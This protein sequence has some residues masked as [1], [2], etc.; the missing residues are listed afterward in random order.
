MLY[1]VKHLFE[2]KPMSLYS[3]Q[4]DSGEWKALLQTKVIATGNI[5]S[6]DKYRDK[7]KIPVPLQDNFV[8]IEVSYMP[9]EEIYDFAL[10]EMM[11]KEGFVK[12][13]G[14][15]ELTGNG[16]LPSLIVAIG[17]IEKLFAGQT[18]GGLQLGAINNT[19]EYSLKYAIWTMRSL[20]PLFRE[21]KGKDLNAR[22]KTEVVDFIAKATDPDDRKVLLKVFAGKGFLSKQDI[23]PATA[24]RH[25]NGTLSLAQVL[26]LP[27]SDLTAILSMNATKFPESAVPFLDPYE[28]AFLDPYDKR[29]LGALKPTNAF[30]TLKV[31][32][33]QVYTTLVVSTD[34]HV[35]E[36]AEWFGKTI[37]SAEQAGEVSAAQVEE[38][39]QRLYDLYDKDNTTLVGALAALEKLGDE[40][41]KA[42]KKMEKRRE[43]KPKSPKPLTDEER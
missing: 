41:K 21:W 16:A 43:K 6:E 9:Q 42:A 39:M 35:E 27:E 23:E 4:E 11:T 2:Q 17:Q 8:G 14:K 24:Y 20:I 38:I 25:R 28:V 26:H 3:P 32:L 40:R 34:P 37:E 7:E 18:I 10:V 5:H 19:T 15:E 30:T 12:G 13:V 36:F 1:R 29:K 22:I 33:H 31:P